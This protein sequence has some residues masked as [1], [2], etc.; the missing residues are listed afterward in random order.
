MKFCDLLNQQL[1]NPKAFQE[2]TDPIDRSIPF[3]C[4]Q[5]IQTKSGVTP[6]TLHHS[7]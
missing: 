3:Y 2:A 4:H 1:P 7:A 6:L 5:R